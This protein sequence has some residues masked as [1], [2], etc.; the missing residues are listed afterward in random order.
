MKN[1]SQTYVSQQDL[2]F[3]IETVLTKF[4]GEIVVPRLRESHFQTPCSQSG[5]LMQPHSSDMFRVDIGYRCSNDIGVG[6]IPLV[7]Y[8]SDQKKKLILYCT[9]LIKEVYHSQIYWT[10]STSSV[11]ATC[12]SGRWTCTLPHWGNSWWPGIT[13]TTHR[14]RRST[15]NQVARAHSRRSIWMSWSSCYSCCCWPCGAWHSLWSLWIYSG[16][17]EWMSSACNINILSV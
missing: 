4:M 15:R 1:S 3:T 5:K 16:Q 7:G 10:T 17:W 11:A 13:A 6:P 8:I 9:V 14:S 12:P 2:R